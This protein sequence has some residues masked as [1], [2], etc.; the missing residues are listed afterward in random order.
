MPHWKYA[1]RSLMELYREGDAIEGAACEL[2]ARRPD[3]KS[4]LT[5]HPLTGKMCMRVEMS[6]NATSE[7]SKALQ[8]STDEE[9][10]LRAGVY[11]DL[12]DKLIA[13]AITVYV[14]QR[15]PLKFTKEGGMTHTHKGQVA[16]TSVP[17]YC[18]I[19]YCHEHIENGI[20]R[21]IASNQKEIE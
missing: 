16:S 17:T 21:R 6:R 5:K 12:G 18:K 1:K 15:R 9:K 7:I 8:L 10:A 13:D 19:K 11:M 14:C 20:A 4:V 2:Y 3:N